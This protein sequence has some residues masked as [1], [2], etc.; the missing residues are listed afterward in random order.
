MIAAIA[1]QSITAGSAYA[2]TPSLTQGTSP[3]TWSLVSGPSG[4]TVNSSTGAVSWPNPT[5]T[6]SPFSV[7]IRATNSLGSDDEQWALT[8]TQVAPVIAAIADQSITAGSAYAYTPSLTQ[9]TGPVTWSLVSGPSG[10]AVNSSSG[11]LSWANPTTTG[12]PF[13]VTIRATNSLGSDD[14]PWALTVTAAGSASPMTTASRTSG[15]APL[16]VFFDAVNPAGGVVQPADGNYYAY[17]FEWDFGDPG[18]GNWTTSG[19]SRNTGLGF[20]NAHVYETPGTYRVKLTVVDSSGASRQYA[21][22]IVVSDFGGTT[23]YVSSSQGSD[24]NDGLDSTRPFQTVAKAVSRIA[25]N[26]RV[27]FKQ[28][29]T[30]TLSSGISSSAAGPVLLGSYGSG[31]RPKFTMTTESNV[32]NANGDDWRIMDLDI[33]SNYVWGGSGGGQVCG[34]SGKN[35]LYLRVSSRQTGSMAY[36]IAPNQGPRFVVDCQI[37]DGRAY[38]VFTF[39]G[40]ERLAILGSRV[41]RVNQEH[42]IRTYTTKLVVSD[43]ALAAPCS[44]K[45]TLALKS[46]TRSRGEVDN[47]YLVATR[48]TSTWNTVHFAVCPEDPFNDQYVSHVLLE[49]NRFV[50]PTTSSTSGTNIIVSAFDVAVRNNL[51][52]NADRFVSVGGTI[53]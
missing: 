8:V 4:M 44:G 19:Y 28:G 32:F 42:C 36:T 35:Q 39:N 37:S 27:L 11:A 33:Q 50:N 52:Q 5:T 17:H 46:G 20:V 3:V 9:G 15:V 12:S 45:V 31:N 14:E 43:N 47:Q 6:G 24:S 53:R 41:E 38:G 1:N 34:G 16:A 22:D 40:S 23:Y 49:A 48:N 18:S 29:D 13:S 21:Q 51:S 30:W 7:T 2:Y 26:T 25:P 10:M